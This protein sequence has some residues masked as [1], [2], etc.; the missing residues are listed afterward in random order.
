MNGIVFWSCSISVDPVI[1]AIFSAKDFSEAGLHPFMVSSAVFLWSF[2]IFGTGR[3]AEGTCPR[4]TTPNILLTDSP[5]WHKKQELWVII[6]TTCAN[7]LGRGGQGRSAPAQKLNYRIH[8]WFVEFFFLELTIFTDNVL[9]FK[10][11][12]N[13]NDKDD[14]SP[15]SINPSH[16]E[17][18][19]RPCQITDWFWWVNFPLDMK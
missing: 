18:K 19:R 17:R 11:G 13:G 12:E 2:I 1:E 5:L 7:P 6:L 9:D 10:P 3:S 14:G 8:S 16:S 15:K 4:P